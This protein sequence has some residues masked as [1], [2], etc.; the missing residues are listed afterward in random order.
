MAW[1]PVRSPLTDLRL[2]PRM[3]FTVTGSNGTTVSN[4][5]INETV[6]PVSHA[7][8]GTS[9]PVPTFL[10]PSSIR[11]SVMRWDRWRIAVARLTPT[12]SA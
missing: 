10:G 3:V 1:T 12:P 4:E 9:W 5:A 7:G 11:P 6:G 8:F 2:S